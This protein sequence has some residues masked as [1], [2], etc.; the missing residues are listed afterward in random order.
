MPTSGITFA[1]MISNSKAVDS[2]QVYDDNDDDDDNSNVDSDHDDRL[3]RYKASNG[4]SNTGRQKRMN[5]LDFEKSNPTQY[6]LFWLK[7][8]LLQIKWT[9]KQNIINF[10][11]EKIG[12]PP[13]DEKLRKQDKEVKRWARAGIEKKVFQ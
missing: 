5:K 12:V 7:D 11:G 13:N 4:R 3:G 1:L 10:E 8:S 2:N 6:D 9:K